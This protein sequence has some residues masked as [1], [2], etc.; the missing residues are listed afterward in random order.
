MGVSLHEQETVIRFNKEE[1]TM[2]VYTAYPS[3]MRKL[4]NSAEYTKVREDRSDGKVIAMYFRADKKMLT[5]RTKRAT[6]R[7]MTEEE[8]EVVRQRMLDL[9]SKGRL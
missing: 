2:E 4:S 7:A 1:K 8:K 5:L 3:L 9:R 6:R